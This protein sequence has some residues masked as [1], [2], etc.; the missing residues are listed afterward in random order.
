[1]SFVPMPRLRRSAT[2]ASGPSRRRGP[3]M[4]FHSRAVPTTRAPSPAINDNPSAGRRSSR[5]RSAALA[6]R[7]AP[8][9]ASSR[10]S[11]AAMSRANSSR[12]VTMAYL[13]RTLRAGALTARHAPWV[14]SLSMS[15]VISPQRRESV[16]R[17]GRI[18]CRIGTRALDQHLVADLETDG[19]IVGTPLVQ[20][21]SAVAGRPGKHARSCLIAVARGANWIADRFG[22]RFGES[23]KLADIEINPAHFVALAFLR[24]QHHLRLNDS[25]TADQTAA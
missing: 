21:V 24:D 17:H 25:G 7:A 23:A 3:A 6:K 20:H 16:E 11:R 19:Q 14:N 4:M 5:R 12:I 10:A 1:M 13:S 9:V 2:T 18:R 15:D 8:K 22:H